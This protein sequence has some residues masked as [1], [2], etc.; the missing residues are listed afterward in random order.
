MLSTLELILTTSNQMIKIYCIP[1]YGTDRR[2]FKSLK[3]KNYDI[4]FINW[5]KPA[6]K[7]SLSDYADKLIPQIDTTEPFALLGMSLG[8]FITVELSHKINPEHIFLLSTVKSSNEIPTYLKFLSQFGLKQIISA[9]LVKSSKWLVEPIFGKL[10][11]ENRNL[12]FQM[13]DD[14]DDQFTTWAGK[15]IAVWR[16]EDQ[17]TPF[18]KITHII[19]DK[20]VLYSKKIKNVHIVKGG[21]HLMILDRAEEINQIIDSE[22]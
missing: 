7:D 5:V 4:K 22:G 16:S 9:K 15:Q 8:G 3:L 11:L 6:E 19:G 12:L 14:A 10:N 21:T 17:L 13:I 1:G 18:Q 20:D 2:L